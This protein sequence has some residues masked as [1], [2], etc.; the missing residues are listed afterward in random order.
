MATIAFLA[1]FLVGGFVGTWI[2]RQKHPKRGAHGR[3]EA[4]D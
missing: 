4:R 1:G 3:F 2:E